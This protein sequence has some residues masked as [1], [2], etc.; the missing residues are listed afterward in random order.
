[1]HMSSLLNM[2]S[3]RRMGSPDYIS[4]HPCNAEPEYL[5]DFLKAGFSKVTFVHFPSS[6]SL[7]P[8]SPS[9]PLISR[10]PRPTLGDHRDLSHTTVY[11]IGDLI[12]VQES[13][14]A[15]PCIAVRWLARSAVH[16]VRFDHQGLSLRSNNALSQRYHKN[17]TLRSH[18]LCVIS[19]H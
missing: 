6:S 2:S 5:L 15:G 1:M 18:D 11:S 9:P 12:L 4:V 8:L 10:R 7:D 3:S 13:A 16:D 14:G 17:R 19:S